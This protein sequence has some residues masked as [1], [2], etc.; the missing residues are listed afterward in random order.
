MGKLRDQ[1][2]ADLQLRGAVPRTQKNY[3]RIVGN[4]AKYFNRS[5]E[6]LGEAELKGYML[7]LMNDHRLAACQSAEPGPSHQ[8]PR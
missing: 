1:M 4:L 2:L 5:P 8:S 3:L 7:Y 6:E